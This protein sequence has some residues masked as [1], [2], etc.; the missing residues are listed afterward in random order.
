MSAEQKNHISKVVNL[1]ANQDIELPIL[2]EIVRVKYPELTVQEI[3]D[4]MFR[5]LCGQE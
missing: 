1:P 4:Q 3:E 5:N 2:A